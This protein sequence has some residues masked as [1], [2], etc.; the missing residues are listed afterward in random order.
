MGEDVRIISLV[1][2]GGEPFLWVG[3][4]GEGRKE[5]EKEGEGER[6]RIRDRSYGRK[7]NGR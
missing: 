4:P 1:S 3:L 7:I 5:E 2:G 6:G